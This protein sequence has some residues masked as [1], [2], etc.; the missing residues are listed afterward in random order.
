MPAPDALVPAP[1]LKAASISGA[2]QEW[3]EVLLENGRYRQDEFTLDRHGFSLMTLHATGGE[4]DLLRAETGASRVHIFARD[5]RAAAPA[6]GAHG[7]ASAARVLQQLFPD[8]AAQLLAYRFAIVHLWRASGPT[9][10]RPLALA[11]WDSIAGPDL[12][13][14]GP[15]R[16]SLDLRHDPRHRWVH[17]PH[18]QPDELLLIK[19][20]DSETD[21]RARCS[22]AT[23]VDAEAPFGEAEEL[24]ALLIWEPRL[25][26]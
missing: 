1:L 18:Q 19:S 13:P 14:A 22:F 17:F 12:I 6:R 5:R 9:P 7:D 16:A 8:E 11:E 15:G 20:Y 24:R 2:A 21:G 25:L 10:P 3:H 26:N 4:A 23:P